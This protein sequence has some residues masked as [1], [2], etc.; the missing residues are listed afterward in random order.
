[1]GE[2]AYYEP[3]VGSSAHHSDGLL[4]ELAKDNTEPGGLLGEQEIELKVKDQPKVD[5][6]KLIHQEPTVME[7]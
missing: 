2:G 6:L 3:L 4:V 7:V 5:Q 1:M